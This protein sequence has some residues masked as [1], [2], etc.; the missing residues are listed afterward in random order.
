MSVAL[1]EHDETGGPELDALGIDLDGTIDEAPAFFQF[2]TRTWPG[3]K[4]VIT[5]RE[6]EAKVRTDVA[7]LGI[8][9]VHIVLVDSF[10]EK[11]DAIRR[12]RIK[13]F[14]D[15]MD[16][17]LLHVPKDVVVFK[18]RNDGNFCYDTRKWLYSKITGRQL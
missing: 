17:V 9:D 11:A 16:E 15:D 2:L 13:V 18:I 6:N 12:L 7:Q 14:F 4:Y 3:P 5:Y 10:A 1:D 8:A